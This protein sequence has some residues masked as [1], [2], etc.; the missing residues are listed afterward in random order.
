M[1]EVGEV[2]ENRMSED[3]QKNKP[4]HIFSSSRSEQDRWEDKYV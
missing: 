2:D 3:A 4:F 1:R